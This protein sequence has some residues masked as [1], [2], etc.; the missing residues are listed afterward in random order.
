[1][2]DVTA[3]ELKHVTTA[4]QKAWIECQEVPFPLYQREAEAIAT[5]A[6]KV[7]KELEQ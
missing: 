3:D 1:M 2:T 6:I 4:V 7:I 5:A